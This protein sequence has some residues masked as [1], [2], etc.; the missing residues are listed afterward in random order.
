M[1]D[2]LHSRIKISGRIARDHAEEGTF[3]ERMF[4]SANR[5]PLR[6]NI[7]LYWRMFLPAN[8]HP[9]RRNICLY[10]RMFLPANRHP[11]RRN[12]RSAVVLDVGGRKAVVGAAELAGHRDGSV[13]DHVAALGLRKTLEHA[14]DA[15]TR[16]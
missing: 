3:K 9:L 8:R 12:I 2:E 13:L 1:N 6:R 14:G 7:C 15:V 16:T 10:W 11:L 5:H 4:L